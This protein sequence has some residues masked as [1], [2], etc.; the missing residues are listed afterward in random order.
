S[1][2]SDHGSLRSGAGEASGSAHFG[3]DVPKAVDVTNRSLSL[4]NHKDAVG[5]RPPPAIAPRSL[6]E[7]LTI[8]ASACALR[9]RSATVPVAKQARE[10]AGL[11]ER[12]PTLRGDPRRELIH[13]DADDHRPSAA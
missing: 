13:D 11:G 10:G 12:R 6:S 8:T 4:S 3:S 9:R 7:R 2:S 5:V 1:S